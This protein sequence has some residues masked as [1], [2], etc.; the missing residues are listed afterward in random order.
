M[1]VR[2]RFAPS[3]T[4]YLHVGGARTA[5]FNW[6][7][8]KRHGGTFILRI[9]DT[10]LERSTAESEEGLLR[11]LR[12]LGLTWDEGPGIGGPHAPYRQS[13]R[14]KIYQEW[15][16]RLVGTGA[17]YPCFCTEDELEKKRQ[18]AEA[19]HRSLHYDG[20][21]RRLSAEEAQRRVA[22]GE[23]HCIRVSVPAKDYAVNDLVRG[24][25]EWKSETLGDFII[26]RS[27]GMPVYNF[28]VVV[29]DADMEIT[30]VI[31]AEEHLT[32]THRQ[33]I[34][35]EALGKPIPQFAHVSLILGADKTKLSKRHG[36]TSVGQYETDGF[37]PQAMVNFL[38]LLGWAEG[39]DKELYSIPELIEKFSLERINPAPAVFDHTKLIW[40][41][42]QHIRLLPVEKLAEL[43]TPAMRGAYPG[44]AR[45]EDGA[46][47]RKLA[48]TVQPALTVI[49]DVVNVAKPLLH[50]GEPADDEAKA[51]L[52]APEVPALLAALAE[53]FKGC[54]WQRDPINAAIKAAGKKAGAKGKGLFMPLRVKLTGSC[55]GPDLINVLDLLGRDEVVRR[56]G[57]S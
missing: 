49:P 33:L 54:D 25:V 15:A 3:P 23:P 14:T 8:A 21:C 20:T 44:D 35:Y 18:Q 57:I 16:H 45:M 9:E 24:R 34:L 26:L 37:L 11:D 1:T 47:L 6:L 55:H 27:N 13:E 2:V 36:A 43:I 40:M 42:G 19:E 51:A 41:N 32:N 7:F 10:D 12:W 30:H 52:T 22:A 29:D 39:I 53:E 31:R 28:C 4:G 50:A 48:A 38:A 17:A 46:F 5:L 56:L